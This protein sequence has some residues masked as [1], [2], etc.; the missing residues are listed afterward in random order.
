MRVIDA[1]TLAEITCCGLS[2]PPDRVFFFDHDRRILLVDDEDLA[3]V[4][5]ETGQILLR[6]QLQLDAQRIQVTEQDQIV[7]PSER[8]VELF[9]LQ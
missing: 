1:E 4:N 3:V 9:S 6:L 7:A 8:T 5:P 2:E